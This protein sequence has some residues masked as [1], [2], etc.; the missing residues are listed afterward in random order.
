[1]LFNQVII[2]TIVDT[3]MAQLFIPPEMDVPLLEISDIADIVILILSVPDS[4]Q[5]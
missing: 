2:P 1:M 4:I 3:Y 5:V